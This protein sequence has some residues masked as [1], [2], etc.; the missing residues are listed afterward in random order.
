[1]TDALPPLPEPVAWTLG[2]ELD[3]RKTTCGAHLWFVDP[4]NSALAPLH[5]ADQMRAYA[6]AAVAAER[7]ACA[8]H[9]DV[10]WA[11]PGAEFA[12]AIRARKP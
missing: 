3:A 5:T 8:T 11:R 7:E 12:A 1:M 6:A 2:A 9:I 10:P 4:V